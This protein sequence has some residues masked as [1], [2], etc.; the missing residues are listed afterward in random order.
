[1][2]T[3]IQI[4]EME[5]RTTSFGEAVYIRVS[6]PNYRLLSWAEIWARF[7]EAYPGRWA[8]QFFPPLSEA[9]DEVNIYHLYVL[10]DAPT[11]VNIRRRS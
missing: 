9:L 10:E 6:T 8:V 7:V 1:M 4:Q 11:G 2:R 3:D 5:Q